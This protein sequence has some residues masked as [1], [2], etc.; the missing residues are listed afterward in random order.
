MPSARR[1]SVRDMFASRALE[2]PATHFKNQTR[3]R[4]GSPCLRSVEEQSFTVCASH[5][6]TWCD[7]DGKTHKLMSA[8]ESAILMGFGDQWRLPQG[9]RAAQKAVGNALC[10]A[11]SQSIMQ[12]AIHLH[13]GTP[14]FT[15]TTPLAA[16]VMTPKASTV[17]VLL[18]AD[19]QSS[20]EV[21]DNRLR[22]I[23]SL[24]RGLHEAG[25]SAA[26]MCE[27]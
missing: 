2:V 3:N 20:E 27:A 16:G 9:S 26:P 8:R 12:A 7:R 10:T 5:A 1:L 11:M 23:E 13:A 18:E 22:T 6:L 24:I 19:E 15:T 17:P 25:A 21:L 14:V 4:N